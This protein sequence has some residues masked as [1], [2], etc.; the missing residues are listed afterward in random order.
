MNPDLS[1][2]VL[3]ILRGIMNPILA[4]VVYPTHAITS[5][6]TLSR[7]VLAQHRT[8][9][10]TI[11]VMLYFAYGSNLN[12][13]HLTDYLDTHGVTLDTELKAEHAL[14][15]NFRFRTNYYSASH[16]A[17][18]CNIEPAS[19]HHVDGVIMTITR[20]MQEALRVKE[21]YPHR[22]D[23]IEVEVHTAA[24]QEP[25]RALTYMVTPT[26]RLDVD[27]PVTARYRNLILAGAKQFSFS[28]KY[29]RALHRQLRVMPSL[30]LHPV[31]QHAS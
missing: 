3:Q 28:A 7:E 8:P 24:T 17:G 31:S 30:G 2:C 18:A 5:E 27:L 14:V 12:L 21:G 26:H 1:R 16:G 13:D 22:Y 4:K 19:G 10:Y 23:E 29:Q 9:W 15:H 20:A 11:C 6:P 25:V